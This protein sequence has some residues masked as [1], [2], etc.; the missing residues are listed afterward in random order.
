[1]QFSVLVTAL[2]AVAAAASAIPA[3]VRLINS[4]RHYASHYQ[5]LGN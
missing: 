3:E 5:G 1:M 2:F 4:I